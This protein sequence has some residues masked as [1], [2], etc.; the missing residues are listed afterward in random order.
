MTPAWG[1]GREQDRV[2]D[3][4]E[5]GPVAPVIGCATTIQGP[6]TRTSNKVDACVLVV[7][8][9]FDSKCIILP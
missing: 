6:I 8:S 7:I 5:E 9:D 2:D 1:H 3:D 4:V